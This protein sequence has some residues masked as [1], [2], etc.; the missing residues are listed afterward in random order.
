MGF[1]R[2]K[3]YIGLSKL[4]S[5]G[6]VTAEVYAEIMGFD[7]NMARMRLCQLRKSGLV[8]SSTGRSTHGRPKQWWVT[9]QQMS[10]ARRRCPDVAR[11]E[12]VSM[13]C[14]ATAAQVKSAAADEKNG[15]KWLARRLE[16]GLIVKRSE[17][18][19]VVPAGVAIYLL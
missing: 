9:E 6:R 17:D 10:D 13:V 14:P 8:T 15:P 5:A 18:E 19:Y 1:V 3:T 2:L 12:K 11:L 16:E 4:H 7:L